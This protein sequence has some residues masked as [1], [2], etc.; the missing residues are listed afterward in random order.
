[1]SFNEWEAFKLGELI[2]IKHGFA[3]KGE[4]F[5]KEPSDDILLTP[6]NFKIG[7]GFKDEKAK[8]YKGQYPPAYILKEGDLIV[9]MTDLSKAG[10]TLGYAAKI[11]QHEKIRYLHNQRLG[12]V[13]FK[14]QDIVPDY[15]Y[16]LLRTRD[17]Q[18]FIVNSATG[19]TVKHT[20]PTLIRQ[21]EFKAP[22][23]KE[24]QTRVAS[25]LSS[26]DDKI[27]LNRQINQTLEA[28]TQ[29]IFREMCV[30]KGDALPKGWKE[31]T[32]EDEFEAERGL[33]YKGA[34]LAESEGVPM[35]N[36]NSIYEGGGYKTGGVKYYTGAYKEKNVVKPGDLIVA[37]TEQGHKYRL[38]GF[39][40]I[41]PKFFG[42][43]GIYSHHIYKLTPKR[44]SYLSSD[45]AY[46]LLLR[47]EVREQ[48]IGFA[49]GTTV[50]MLKV[51]GLKKPTFRMPPKD[52]VE[53]FTAIAKANRLL[54]E[55]NIEENQT[56]TALRDSLLPKLMKGELEVKEELCLEK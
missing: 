26:F 16:W 25:I 46:H 1:M 52:I 9:T 5:S 27:E 18:L 24:T 33:S 23:N 4:F 31:K 56:L 53:K 49:N 43:L 44:S 51:E 29:T 47:N 20:S 35:H 12:L 30:P 3:F 10:D 7:G 40:A 45:F 32:F 41:V 37:N 19:T 11:P 55:A 2:D 54:V 17:Y 50:N 28:I 6:G 36:L 48:V 39:P 13:V 34:G 15:L 8:Y 22:K 14:K 42:D 38:I 21:Y